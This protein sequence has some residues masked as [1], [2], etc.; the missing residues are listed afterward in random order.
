M[1]Q[2]S[3]NRTSG[4]DDPVTSSRD[5]G[6]TSYEGPIN[7]IGSKLKL[8]SISPQPI[9][10]KMQNDTLGNLNKISCPA[11]NRTEINGKAK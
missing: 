7:A 2:D 3:Y 5:E 6:T 8:S 11:S 9:Y 1:Y 4:Q 10:S